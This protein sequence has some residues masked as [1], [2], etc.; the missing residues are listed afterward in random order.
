MMPTLIA[1]IKSSYFDAPSFHALMYQEDE[2]S[3]REELWGTTFEM[4][5]LTGVG[6]SVVYNENSKIIAKYKGEFKDGKCDGC[7]ML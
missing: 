1:L 5:E 4:G 2:K 7:V 3:Y 6:I